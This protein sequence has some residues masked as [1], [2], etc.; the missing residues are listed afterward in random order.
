LITTLQTI[1]FLR[2]CVEEHE[3]RESSYLDYKEEKAKREFDKLDKRRS[4]SLDQLNRYNALKAELA[5]IEQ[6][7]I[8]LAGSAKYAGWFLDELLIVRQ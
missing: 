6:E 4:F 3:R 8:A 5:E 1:E 7:R 2:F